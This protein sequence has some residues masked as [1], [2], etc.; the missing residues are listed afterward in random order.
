MNA[1]SPEMS[2]AVIPAGWKDITFGWTLDLNWTGLIDAVNTKIDTDGYSLFT[3]FFMLVLVQG[4][5]CERRGACSELR[6]AADAGDEVAEG[7]RKD[8][9]VRHTVVL[10]FPRYMMIAGLTVLALV[11]LSPMLRNMGQGIDFE[12]VLPYALKNLIPVGWVGL[13][14]AGL[15]AAFMSTYAATINAAPAYVVNDIYKRFINPNAEPRRYVRLS[16]LVSVTFVILGFAFGFI[17]ESIN[18]VTLW[19]V[20]ALWGGYT[21]ANVLKWYWWRLERIWIFLG[22]GHRHRRI[23]RDPVAVPDRRRPV[24]LPVHPGD[25][26]RRLHRRE[27]PHP[28]RAG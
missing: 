4:I 26:V 2:S 1:V 6:H 22:H 16:Y 27:L 5:P 28:S 19:I 9:R 10:F 11:F 21:A 17:V 7:S 25:L 3:I 23:H 24:C 14:L 15:L 8:E 13:I 12:M 18:Q 20:N